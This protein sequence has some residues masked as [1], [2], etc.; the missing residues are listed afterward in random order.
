MSAIR[1]FIPARIVML[2]RKVD[3]ICFNKC[4]VFNWSVLFLYTPTVKL[5]IDLLMNQADYFNVRLKKIIIVVVVV[6]GL[7]NLRSCEV[8]K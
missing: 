7:L 8:G 2:F 4:K 5:F 6:V 1:L 3:Q